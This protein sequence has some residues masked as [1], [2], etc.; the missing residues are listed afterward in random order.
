MLYRGHNSGVILGIKNKLLGK[1]I[2][3]VVL[4]FFSSLFSYATYR[5]AI[6]E[7]N[8][9]K[10]SITAEGTVISF[11]ERSSNKGD[12]NYAP[13]VQYSDVEGNTHTFVSSLASSPP[14]YAIGQKVTILISSDGGIPQI[15]SFMSQW[16]GSII[17]GIFALLSICILLLTTYATIRN[18]RMSKLLDE[19]GTM[20][21][22]KV[23]SIHESTRSNNRSSGWIIQA[24]WLDPQNNKIYTFESQKIAYNPKDFVG[25]TIDVTIVS[26]DPTMYKIDISKLPTTAN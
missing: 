25:D 18:W 6:G 2:F 14:S 15:K 17:G 16:F 3:F 1:A 11:V 26:E 22:A 12:T 9:I 24:Q 21:Q 5:V 23:V 13:V 19:E 10:T 8:F 4:I 7:W 20:I